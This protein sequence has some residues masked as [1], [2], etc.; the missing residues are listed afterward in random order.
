MKYVSPFPSNRHVII[1]HGCPDGYCGALLLSDALQFEGNVN[2]VLMVPAQY[3]QPLPWDLGQNDVVILVDFSY[4]RDV[5]VEL[6]NKV[7]YVIVLDHHKTAKEELALLKLTDV[8]NVAVFFDMERSGARLAWDF[9]KCLI[10]SNKEGVPEALLVEVLP[11]QPDADTPELVRYIEDRD[12]WRFEL[13][14]SREITTYLKSLPFIDSVW[15]SLFITPHWT[16]NFSS[17]A[18]E[19]EAILRFQKQQVT[20]TVDHAVDINF[21][22]RPGSNESMPVKIVNTTVNHSEV[23][24]ELYTRYDIPFTVT[25]F[26]NEED[27]KFIYSLRSNQGVD[28]SKIAKAFGGGGHPVAAGFSSENMIK[29][30][31]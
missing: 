25:W 9:L 24:E 8:N 4:K 28:V 7:Q 31:Y 2:N 17:M 19:G 14:H 5:M 15:R 23:A 13:P 1:H 16:G 10:I 11:R 29:G 22:L 18:R 3:G 20:S 6:C 30:V 26:Y 27:G 21:P 12:L